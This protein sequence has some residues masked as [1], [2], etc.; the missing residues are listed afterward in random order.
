M[1]SAQLPPELYETV[2][3]PRHYGSHPSGVECIQVVQHMTFNVGTAVKH[4][5]RIGLK[6]GSAEIEDLRK[7]R[8]YLAFEIERLGGTP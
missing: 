5:W 8:Q 3:H 7:A 1:N 4:L 6:P 2:S